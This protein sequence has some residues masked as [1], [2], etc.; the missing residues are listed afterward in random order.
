[1]KVRNLQDVF[2]YLLSFTN[3]EQNSS[4]FNPRNYRLDRMNS[5]LEHFGNPHNAF[6]VLHVAGTKGKGS[7]AAFLASVLTAAG[8][9]TGLYTSPH[10][11]SF[12]E[13]ISVPEILPDEKFLVRLDQSDQADGGAA[14]V[15]A[16]L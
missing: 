8:F 2:T 13:R 10:V 12:L 3:L 16:C 5:L 4:L 9:R 1:M 6:Q 15:P 11:S 7:T 14:S